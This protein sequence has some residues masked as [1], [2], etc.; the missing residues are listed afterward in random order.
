MAVTAST[1]SVMVAATA[2]MG[3]AVLWPLVEEQLVPLL[4][5]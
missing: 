2:L 3:L 5:T 1:L 4:T